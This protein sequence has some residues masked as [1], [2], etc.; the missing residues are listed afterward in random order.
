MSY[1]FYEQKQKRRKRYEIKEIDHT[2]KN[3]GKRMK[4]KSNIVKVSLTYI[5]FIIVVSPITDTAVDGVV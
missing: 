2:A 1:Y 4:C 5:V 3:L